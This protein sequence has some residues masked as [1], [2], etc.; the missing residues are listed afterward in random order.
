MSATSIGLPKLKIAFEKAAQATANRAKKGYVGMIVR[1]AKAQ[2]LHK[3]VS[4]TMIPTEL[5]VDNQALVKLA[6]EGSDRG[7]P[8]LVY[9]VVIATGTEDTTALEGGLKLLESVSVDYLAGPAD[10]TEDELEVLNEWVKAQ[11]AAYRTVKLVRPFQTTG[12]D[13]MGIIEVDET[14]MKDASGSLTAAKYCARFAGIFA[15]IPMGMSATY[16]ALPE[17]T[18]VTA[19]S[20]TEQTAAIN[21][22][23]LILLHDGQKAKIARAVNSLTTI[24]VNGNEDWRKVKIVEGMDLITYFLRTTIEDSYLGQ[25]PNT[26]DN[27]QLL[28]AYILEYLHYLERAE[29]LSPGESFCEIDYDRQLNYLKSQGVEVADLTRQQVLAYQ[30]GSWVFL[31]CGGW[32]VDAMEDFEVLF[33]ALSLPGAA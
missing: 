16:A 3:L 13:D 5:G 7:G 18:A 26:Y 2:G 27:K 12:S 14:G 28:V 15:G 23:K 4:D 21:A 22:G 10:V 11:R 29:V 17:L 33:S 30:T 31:R 6:F 9:L 24:P 8:S 20:E 25:Y 1:D 32:L 19:R